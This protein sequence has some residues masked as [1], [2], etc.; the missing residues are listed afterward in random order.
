MKSDNNELIR[1]NKFISN[2]GICSRRKADELIEKGKI[3]VNG[4]IIKI[5]GYKVKEKDI[6]KY[7]NKIL[8]KEKSIYIILNKPKNYITTLDDPQNRKTVIQLVKKATTER[9]YPVGRLD[10]NTTGLLLLTNDGEIAQKLSHPSKGIRKI[11]EVELDKKIDEKD[12]IKI[13]KGIKLEDG[14]AL[15]DFIKVADKDEKQI[16]IE[17]HIGKNRIIRRIF[18]SLGY[19]VKKLDR[20][21]YGNLDKKMLPRGKWRFLTKKEIYDIKNF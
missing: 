2:A 7:N 4:E 17:I 13:E 9:I 20:V 1:L 21:I 10:R 8:K 6:I 16:L 18:E 15:V 19:E 3:S 12:I 11:Y 5:L 14:I